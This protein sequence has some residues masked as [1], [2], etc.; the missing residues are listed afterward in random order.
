MAKSLKYMRRLKLRKL[1]PLKGVFQGEKPT[2]RFGA[3]DRQVEMAGQ[4]MISMKEGMTK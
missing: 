1:H 2:R 4:A 3:L